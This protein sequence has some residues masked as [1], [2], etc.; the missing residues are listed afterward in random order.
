M[1]ERPLYWSI[2]RFSAYIEETVVFYHSITS[3][4]CFACHNITAYIFFSPLIFC[5]AII[6]ADR[7]DRVIDKSFYTWF[8]LYNSFQKK[9]ITV[10]QRLSPQLIDGFFSPLNSS[11]WLLFV[12]IASR[13]SAFLPLMN[14]CSSSGIFDFITYSCFAFVINSSSDNSVHFA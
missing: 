7:G 10:Y 11:F 9:S 12:T 13:T 6:F 1:W 2:T 3:I 14:R 5:I 4:A 8:L